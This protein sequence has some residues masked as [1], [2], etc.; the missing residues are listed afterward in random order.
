MKIPFRR[1]QAKSFKFNEAPSLK[2]QFLRRIRHSPLGYTQ[3]R[4]RATHSSRN[5][6]QIL[7]DHER[8]S[9]PKNFLTQTFALSHSLARQKGGGGKI[10]E[11][12][13][14]NVY[15]RS[16]INLNFSMSKRREGR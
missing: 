6:L 14:R 4:R 7:I 2:R 11:F 5:P 15:D 8:L 10:S 13:P 3:Y 1:Q 9:I 12:L 16:E